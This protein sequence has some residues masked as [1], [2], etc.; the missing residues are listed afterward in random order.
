MKAYASTVAND[1]KADVLQRYLV[2]H[3][4]LLISIGGSNIKTWGGGQENKMW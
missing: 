2:C 3:L 4:V 1:I